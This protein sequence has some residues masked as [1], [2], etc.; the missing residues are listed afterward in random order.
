MNMKRLLTAFVLACAAAI[1]QTPSSPPSTLTV[2]AKADAAAQAANIGATTL[3][4][5]PASG[6]GTYRVSCYIVLTRPATTSS[7]IPQCLM[8]YTD[9]DTSVVEASYITL[10][11][12]TNNT[13]GSTNV[14]ATSIPTVIMQVK[15]LTNIQYS[16]AGYASSG[17]TTMQYSFHVKL[18]YL[19]Q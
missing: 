16:T 12:N 15:A 3:Y 2:V 9:S 11:T 7:T 19:G 18:E 13:V 4:A 10:G 17:T 1:A 14:W 5:V 6:A 8:A